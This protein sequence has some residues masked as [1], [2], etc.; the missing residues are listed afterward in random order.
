M[1]IAAFEEKFSR[2]SYSVAISIEEADVSNSE[3]S[4]YYSYFF[5]I[6]YHAI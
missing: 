6:I 3:I 5:I 2:D 1:L 4:I